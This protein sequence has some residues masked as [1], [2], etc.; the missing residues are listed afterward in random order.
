MKI[1]NV[2]RISNPSRSPAESR[3][4]VTRLIARPSGRCSPALRISS[5][6]WR[7]VWSASSIEVE[8]R[9]VGTAVGAAL[10]RMV[11][12]N[13]DPP[14]L[15]S[16]SAISQ[17]SASSASKAVSSASRSTRRAE[18]A[19]RVPLAAGV[20]AAPPEREGFV[21][22]GLEQGDPSAARGEHRGHGHQG[23]GLAAP[24]LERGEGDQLHGRLRAIGRR[25]EPANLQTGTS[26]DGWNCG[27]PSLQTCKPAD[28]RF[29]IGAPM[30]NS[31]TAPVQSCH[32]AVAQGCI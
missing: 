16:T 17:P 15:V 22:V 8:E 29:R 30:Q 2:F 24:A 19:A 25:G 1:G 10:S 6:T 28:G 13:S 9:V 27:S 3:P 26:A 32:H 14:P 20:G 7:R 11:W 5:M 4:G 31:E 12:L 18:G 21:V 23:G